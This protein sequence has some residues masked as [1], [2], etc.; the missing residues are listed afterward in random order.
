MMSEHLEYVARV[1][2]PTDG[3]MGKNGTAYPI[4]HDRIITAAHVLEGRDK[5]RPV[6]VW[7]NQHEDTEPLGWQPA[8]VTWDGRD[9]QVDVAV[10]ETKFPEPI[11]AFAPLSL[12]PPEFDTPFESRGFAAIGKKD[13]G[14]GA[15]PI[16]GKVIQ[17][18]KID[19]AVTL[20]IEFGAT[21]ETD[22]KGASGSPVIINGNLVAVLANCP[23]GFGATRAN[24]VPFCILAQ[25]H[26]FFDAI[27]FTADWDQLN[28]IREERRT[29]VVAQLSNL[30]APHDKLISGLILQ[31]RQQGED[32]GEADQ[33]VDAAQRAE[34]LAKLLVSAEPKISLEAMLAMTDAMRSRLQAE[35]L[36]LIRRVSELVLPVTIDKLDSSIRLAR[37]N[38]DSLALQAAS[39]TMAELAIASLENRQARFS[40]PN[41]D[42]QDLPAGEGCLPNSFLEG[43]EFG[44]S[45]DVD[46]KVN[47]A[48]RHIAQKTRIFP[49]EATAF[50]M[51][52]VIE[53]LRECL[54]DLRRKNGNLYFAFRTDRDT[55]GKLS[56]TAI[57]LKQKIG[58]LAVICLQGSGRE[59]LREFQ[60]LKS[61]RN[62]LH[63]LSPS[64]ATQE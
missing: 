51:P 32:T 14:R 52:E 60:S 44:D 56:D 35:Q 40:N 17:Y 34:A 16:T 15:V 39:L 4:A 58:E 61:L 49:Q 46:D 13:D 21:Q 12:K 50:D 63:E 3:D 24:A 64:S 41:S 23:V 53:I 20:G 22:W 29:V 42:T 38:N 62:L 31:L 6:E 19:K 54:R 27:E 48:I 45:A 2:A 59:Y 11:K 25:H 7:W 30:L 43:G 57:A 5:K 36:K 55:D 28:R 26:A 33:K 9:E 18:V 47:A 10:L 8:K 37:Q 1:F